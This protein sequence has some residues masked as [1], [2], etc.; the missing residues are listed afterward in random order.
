MESRFN[1]N[2]LNI[3]RREIRLL[4][5]LPPGTGP[6]PV[7]STLVN[8]TLSHVSL[9]ANPNYQALSYVWGNPA[10]T[11]PICVN[12]DIFLATLNLEA[13]LRHLR[14]TDASSG[15]TLWAD[16]LCIDQSN[17]AEKNEQVAL[18]GAIYRHAREV[19]IWLGQPASAAQNA[20]SSH[21]LWAQLKGLGE[22]A[23]KSPLGL[24][25]DHLVQVDGRAPSWLLEL[26]LGLQEL[27]SAIS[28]GYSEQDT[29]LIEPLLRLLTQP[30]WSRIWVV[31]EASLAGMARVVWG[32]QEMYWGVLWAALGHIATWLQ[33]QAI[34]LMGDEAQHKAFFLLERSQPCWV[35]IVGAWER[36]NRDDGVGDGTKVKLIDM[37]LQTSITSDS[38]ATDPRDCI[39]G[40][41]GMVEDADELGIKVDYEQSVEALYES[42]ARA[43][44]RTQ[45][46]KML[47][48]CQFSPR[49]QD[50][51]LPS[52]VP[53][54]SSSLRQLL[55]GL[56]ILLPSGVYNASGLYEAR[57]ARELER[58]KLQI[59]ELRLEENK[60]SSPP[61]S[62]DSV[63]PN[64]TTAP[65]PTLSFPH[66]ENPKILRIHAAHLDTIL[67][68]G[69]AWEE[70]N[71]VTDAH[72]RDMLWV[73]EL[74][75]L[76]ELQRPETV[77]L[78]QGVEE[79]HVYTPTQQKEALWRTP[80]AD[81][82]LPRHTYIWL[83]RST[84][85]EAIGYDVLMGTFPMHV[86]SDEGKAMHYQRSRAYQKILR[87]FG[88]ERRFFVTEKG[89]LGLGPDGVG[90]GD[91]V[92]VVVGVGTPFVL[93]RGGG[94]DDGCEEYKIV[95]EA[96]VHGIMD[97]EF[98][99]TRPEIVEVDV[100]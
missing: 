9:D 37:L 41:L 30:W 93:R 29:L 22:F 19:V 55:D 85:T 36:V 23:A 42:V 98:M 1:Y 21:R 81:R 92:F 62:H 91:E 77:G 56:R 95:G 43:L 63:L 16:A 61:P 73:S 74:E 17:N 67:A 11:T 90:V 44:L 69:P 7:K 47:Q 64:P 35:P 86:L 20:S 99:Q 79:T 38:S 76:T 53:D 65:T 45:G 34:H 58:L 26:N 97:G 39:Y 75:A 54:W 71:N 49:H 70:A 57:V 2:P 14:K 6:S 88:R 68:T 84:G 13:A 66:P 33:F 46:L 18:M 8:C 87:A 3:E 25:F 5:L 28:I 52:W 31:Q 48:C 72:L 78:G 60:T 89:Y 4:T 10:V 27:F 50:G 24:N 51:S 59:E 40:L 82:G 96:Y 94:G 32:Q 12:G 15:V 80:V 100:C 83:P